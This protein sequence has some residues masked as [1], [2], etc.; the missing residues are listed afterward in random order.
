MRSREFERH[1][2]RAG[3]CAPIL[4]ETTLRPWVRVA[5]RVV[6]WVAVTLAVVA[7]LCEYRGF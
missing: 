7:M 4:S 5:L 6:Y 1:S 2:L 3:Q